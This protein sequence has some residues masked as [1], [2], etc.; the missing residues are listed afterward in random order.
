[1]L[2][3]PHRRATASRY[4]TLRGDLIA[5]CPDGPLWVDVEAFE[6]AA[7]TA[8][9]SREPAA[10]RSAIELYVGEL[11]PEDRYEDWTLERREHLR[12]SL[13][14]LVELAA[15][16]EER[17]EY[18]PGID[19]LRRALAEEPLDEEARAGLMRLLALRGGQREAILQYEAL[20][21]LSASRS[22]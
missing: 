3:P 16:H 21:K 13:A 9:R 10:Y 22:T 11:L 12:A 19:A 7:A 6:R 4:L 17:G 14:L 5:L 1:M 20:R 18:Q 2:E 15:L 8:R